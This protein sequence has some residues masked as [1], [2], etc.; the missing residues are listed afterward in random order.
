MIL[1]NTLPEENYLYLFPPEGTNKTSE[2]ITQRRAYQVN[3]EPCLTL[4]FSLSGLTPLS[5]Q[6]LSH[7]S[8]AKSAAKE[9]WLAHPSCSPF[10]AAPSHTVCGCM[11]IN[12]V[13]EVLTYSQVLWSVQHLN[14]PNPPWFFCLVLVFWN[15]SKKSGLPIHP[16]TSD[17]GRHS[18]LSVVP[19][20]LPSS[21]SCSQQG[22]PVFH[23]A[24]AVLRPPAS[25]TGIPL[26]KASP[27]PSWITWTAYENGMFRRATPS[28]QAVC[29]G[30]SRFSPTVLFWTCHVLLAHLGKHSHV[31]KIPQTADCPQVNT[32]LA[33]FSLL[34]DIPWVIT[35]AYNYIRC[36]NFRKV[37]KWIRNSSPWS[38]LHSWRKGPCF[39]RWLVTKP[40]SAAGSA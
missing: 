17:F 24:Q 14:L 15:W 31:A 5:L 37:K 40:P 1:T 9:G 29:S 33:A 12:W 38:N 4:L 28:T 36:L 11:H 20:L 25:F 32:V 39:S 8:A 10:S 3:G 19:R 16:T 35:C 26:Q 22:Y 34:P 30:S 2:L 6:G 18:S 27:A 7:Q 21:S 23:G 13:H